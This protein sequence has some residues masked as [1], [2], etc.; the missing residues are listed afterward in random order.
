[1][2][3]IGGIQPGSPRNRRLRGV[4]FILGVLVGAI[5]FGGTVAVAAGITANPTKDSVFVNG[6][7]ILAEVYKIGGANYFKLRD[8]ASA[9]DFSVV[10][11]AQGQRVLIDPSRPYNPNEQYV[12][13][14]AMTPD[15]MKAELIRLTNIQREKAGVSALTVL[16]ELMDCAQAKAQDMKDGGYS[17]HNSPVYGTPADMIRSF[18]PKAKAVGEILARW[19]QTP[20]EASAGWIGS[21]PHYEVMVNPK[22]THIGIGFIEVGNGD[23]RWV[24]QFCQL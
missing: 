23:F 10:Y 14:P 5:M 21:Q 12:E 1:M 2:K 19:V 11:D 24:V 6:Q 17:G 7:E 18:V 20:A 13:S 8:I 22:Y 15:E 3:K 16:P 9:V 4:E